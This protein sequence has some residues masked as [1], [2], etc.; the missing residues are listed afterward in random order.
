MKLRVNPILKKELKL[1]AR[2]FK[3]P[4]GISVYGMIFSLISLLNLIS[5]TRWLTRVWYGNAMDWGY[6]S[7]NSLNSGFTVLAIMQVVMLCI[8]VP[9]L[10]ASSIAGERERQTLDI[11][12]TAPVSSFSIAFFNVLPLYFSC[13]YEKYRRKIRWM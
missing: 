1:G 3:F 10:T 11:M 5:N 2:T 7:Y 13:S 4:L 8:I 12:L 6:I 9:V